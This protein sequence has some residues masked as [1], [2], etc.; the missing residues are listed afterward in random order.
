MQVLHRGNQNVV[1]FSG[2]YPESCGEH[3]M[4]RVI[5]DAPHY[6]FGVFKALWA[7]LG[8]EFRG[9]L[10]EG[11]LPDKARRLHAV[12]S[13]TLADILRSINKYSNN[14]MTRQLLLTMGAEK[15]GPPGTVDKGLVV[16]HDWL[17]RQRLSFPEL[18]VENG[19][20]LS[21][22]A[23]ISARH[24]GEL[25][26]RGYNSAFMPE[27]VSSLPLAGTDGTL[28]NR[29]VGTTLERRLRA[30]TGSLEDVKSIAGY[31]IDQRGRQLVVVCIQNHPMAD[32]AAGE[33]V[34][35]ALLS[36]LYERP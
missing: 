21:R 31:M 23:R 19:S 9:G 30:K 22:A 10:Q 26:A 17:R 36:W 20:G 12:E 28:Q 16:M 27:F 33:R 13:R 18:V 34:Q 2:R 15:A 29:F 4:Y 1:R 5:S 8:G 32:T 3:A 7:D 11:V 35:E 24:L 14:V 25:L 6:V